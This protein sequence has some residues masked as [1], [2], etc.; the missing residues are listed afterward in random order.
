LDAY[1]HY[2][3]DQAA[4]SIPLAMHKCFY[5]TDFCISAINALA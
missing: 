4:E 3:A 1:P 5:T 2:H